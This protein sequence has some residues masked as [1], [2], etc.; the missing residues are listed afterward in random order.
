MRKKKENRRRRNESNKGEN[1]KI[2]GPEIDDLLH[3]RVRC[4]CGV[5]DA[6][7]VRGDAH[8]QISSNKCGYQKNQHRGTLHLLISY[9]CSSTILSKLEMLLRLCFVS[10]GFLKLLFLR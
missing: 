8:E 7:W 5:L 2:A 4:T 3:V 9:R 1:R 6:S 10:F